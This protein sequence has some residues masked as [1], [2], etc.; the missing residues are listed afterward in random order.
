MQT[1]VYADI[2]IDRHS[3]IHSIKADS[4]TGRQTEKHTDIQT[5]READRQTYS[6]TVI[7]SNRQINR[8]A[9]IGTYRDRPRHKHTDRQPDRQ[10]HR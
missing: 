10:T 4:R 5:E 1:Y 2:Q 3:Y 8:Q 6:L 7:H 9:D